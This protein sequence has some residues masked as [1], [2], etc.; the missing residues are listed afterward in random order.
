MKLTINS[1]NNIDRFIYNYLPTYIYKLF[2]NT[3]DVNRLKIFDKELGINSLEMLSYLLRHLIIT[4]IGS[5]TYNIEINKNLKINN[6]LLE[7]YLRYITYGSRTL[8][9][10]P[11]IYNIF[12]VVKENIDI[13]YKRWEDT[14]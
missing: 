8:K 1:K 3:V 13:I 2:L 6:V 4:K 7:P 10:Y 5:E 12:K 14:I 11:I 9:G